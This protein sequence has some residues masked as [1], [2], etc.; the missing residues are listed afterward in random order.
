MGLVGLFILL[1]G[2]MGASFAEETE[3][4]NSWLMGI[5]LTMALAAGAGF[6]A[7]LIYYS[8]NSVSMS[9]SPT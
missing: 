7:S 8:V 4:L 3:I 6:V 9:I 2:L 5:G 1:L